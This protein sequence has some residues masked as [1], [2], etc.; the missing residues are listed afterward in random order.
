MISRENLVQNKRAA[1][2]NYD[3]SD[4]QIIERRAR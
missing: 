3:L 2:R 4:A 1:G